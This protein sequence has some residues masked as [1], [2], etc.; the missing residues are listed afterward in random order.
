MDLTDRHELLR[1]AVAYAPELTRF[2]RG[3]LPDADDAQDL[4]QELYLALLKVQSWPAEIRHPKAYLFK[5]AANLAHQHR[6]RIKAQPRHVALE[7][8]PAEVL[9]REHFAVEGNAPEAACALAERL[10][11]LEDRLT[12]LSP[13]VQAAV[14]WHHRDGY[15]CDEIS[16]KLSVVTHRVKKYLVRGLS[17]CRALEAAEQ[18]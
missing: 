18:T 1:A 9:E 13:K 4:M 17:Y 5:I 14:V 2:I 3:Q 10:A 7:E 8:V 16:E 11:Q 12:Q 6:Q 15:T